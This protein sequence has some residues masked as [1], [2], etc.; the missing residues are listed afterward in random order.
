VIPYE[1]AAAPDAGKRGRIR[2]EEGKDVT[3]VEIP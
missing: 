3:G 1:S 2:P